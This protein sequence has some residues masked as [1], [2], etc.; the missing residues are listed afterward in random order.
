MKGLAYEL[1]SIGCKIVD[2]EI[3]EYVLACL[4]DDYNALVA[5]VNANPTTTLIDLFAPL[6]A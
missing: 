4:D 5:S 6:S 1:A 3:K 2:D